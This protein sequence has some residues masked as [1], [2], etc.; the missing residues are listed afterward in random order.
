M[1]MTPLIDGA[2]M[3]KEVR[4]VARKDNRTIFV[5]EGVHFALTDEQMKQLAELIEREL[6]GE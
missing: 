6:K 2:I 3:M 1:I 4:K 5:K